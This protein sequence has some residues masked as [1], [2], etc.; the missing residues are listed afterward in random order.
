MTLPLRQTS[1]RGDLLR[2]PLNEKAI[3]VANTTLCDRCG[4]SGGTDARD[5]CS[6]CDGQKRR[7][8][9]G[10]EGYLTVLVQAGV[11]FYLDGRDVTAELFEAAPS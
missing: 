9:D 2:T 4:G 10:I 5:P 3:R 8:V 1:V 11:T 7:P 6:L